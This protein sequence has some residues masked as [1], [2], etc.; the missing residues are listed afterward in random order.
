M[1]TNKPTVLVVEDEVMLLQAI[2]KKLKSS[3]I[4][5]LSATSAQ[6]ALDYLKN[7]S[8][9]P[10][11]IWLDYYLGDSDGITFMKKLR[12]YKKFANIPVM[13]I[14]NSASPQKV[15]SM[16]KLGIKKYLIKAD[17]RLDE[18][19]TDLKELIKSNKTN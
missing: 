9:V 1:A 11:A 12:S 10:E 15:Q 8:R 16:Y 13:V 5:T 17:H 7:L 14:S 6:Q 3:N 19:I 4:N 2:C 18:I